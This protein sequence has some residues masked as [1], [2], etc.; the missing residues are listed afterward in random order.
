MEWFIGIVFFIYGLIFG[1]FYNVV[2]LRVPINNFLSQRNSYCY[3]CKRKLSWSELIPVVSYIIQKGKCKGCGDSI[4]IIYPVVELA[5]GLLFTAT[6][7]FF[8]LS[9]QT[10]FGLLLVSMIV[11]VTVSDI[12]YQKIP[13][14]ILLFFLPL[15][16]IIKAFFLDTNWT[17]S[18]VGAALAFLLIGLIIYITKGG[19]GIGDLKFFSL[20]GLL[21][22]WQLFLLLFLLSTLY[23][24]VIN[25][26]LL[27]LGKVTRKTKVPF[28]PY[29]GASAVTV[30][31]FGKF[32]LHWYLSSF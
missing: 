19:M 23:G 15:F 20:F 28:G 31:Y 25:G 10:I 3:T 16:L 27:A 22:G 4:S 17:S 30:L 18:I 24:A 11:I 21:F 14:K 8:G 26:I 7:L 12:T 5:T 32:I 9:F 29:I 13:N 6:Y 2:G 1:S